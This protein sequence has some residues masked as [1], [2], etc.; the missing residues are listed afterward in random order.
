MWPHLYVHQLRATEL[1]SFLSNNR[2]Y[3]TDPRSFHNSNIATTYLPID[4]NMTWLDRWDDTLS[5]FIQMFD[6]KLV[7]Y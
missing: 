6:E 1:T 2:L 5:L 4:R 7:G 3:F